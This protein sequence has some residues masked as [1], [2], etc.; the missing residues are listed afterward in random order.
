MTSR[1]GDQVGKRRSLN[2]AKHPEFLPLQEEVIQGARRAWPVPGVVIVLDN[3]A[4]PIAQEPQRVQGVAHHILIG[5]V[6]VNE[7]EIHGT[8]SALKSK[9]T[10]SP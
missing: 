6:G 7:G 9:V 8:R 2:V 3:A 10:E 1:L 4:V 5:V